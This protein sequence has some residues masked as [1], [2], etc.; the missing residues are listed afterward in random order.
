MTRTAEVAEK[1]SARSA[2]RQLRR[3]A[4][5]GREV[6]LYSSSSEDV[7]KA[8]M[9]LQKNETII[10]LWSGTTYM[11]LCVANKQITQGTLWNVILQTFGYSL[12]ERELIWAKQG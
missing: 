10:E 4:R 11:G 3:E 9:N 2:A 6:Q 5:L 1:E 12:E 7:R 8:Y